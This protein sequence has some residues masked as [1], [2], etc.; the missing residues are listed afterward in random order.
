[1]VSILAPVVSEIELV[2]HP[3]P[4]CTNENDETRYIKTTDNA[5][6]EHL[7]KYLAMRMQ[8]D[9]DKNEGN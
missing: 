1:M 5:T 8:L 7:R 4:G 2:F 9:A 3:R 6:I